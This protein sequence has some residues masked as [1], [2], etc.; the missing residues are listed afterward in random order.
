MSLIKTYDLGLPESY[1]KIR[2]MSL[3]KSNQ[4]KSKGLSIESKPIVT[5]SAKQVNIIV[6]P[7]KANQ[8]DA[9]LVNIP[10][11]IAT[12]LIAFFNSCPREEIKPPEIKN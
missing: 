2:D 5:Q 3:I 6:S 1:K 7:E 8:L 10:H 4:R 11:G 9:W 12:Q